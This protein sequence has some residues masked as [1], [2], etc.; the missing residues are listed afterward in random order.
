ML[1]NDFVIRFL[2]LILHFASYPSD[3]LG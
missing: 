3:F 1:L 2:K